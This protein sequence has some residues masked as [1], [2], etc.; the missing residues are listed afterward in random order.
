MNGLKM[1]KKM[2]NQEEIL[3]VEEKRNLLEKEQRK[4]NPGKIWPKVGR[5]SEIE[6]EVEGSTLENN[7]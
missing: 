3:R 7:I 6:E 4:E 5:S 1:K 2:K